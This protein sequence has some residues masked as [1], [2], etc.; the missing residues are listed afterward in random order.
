MGKIPDWPHKWSLNELRDL[1]TKVI[2]EK[3][4]EAKN[5]KE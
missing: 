5:A 1:I 4:E 2:E 3:K